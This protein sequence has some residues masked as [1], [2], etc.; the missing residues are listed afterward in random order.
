[1]GIRLN[2]TLKKII[3]SSTQQEINNAILAVEEYLASGTKM[4]L[5]TLLCECI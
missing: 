3:E 1:M 5:P 4:V 2:S